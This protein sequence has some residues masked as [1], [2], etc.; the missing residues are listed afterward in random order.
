MKSF[1][2][3]VYIFWTCK[4][5]EEAETISCSLLDQHLIACASILPSVR[6]IYRWEGK[7]EQ[8]TETKVILKTQSKHFTA[9]CDYIQKHGSYQ[10]PEISEV[11]IQEANPEYAA[12]LGEET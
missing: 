10:V 11:K 5:S 8:G 9:I 3:I 1:P 2:S 12:W 7:I 6:S 4:D